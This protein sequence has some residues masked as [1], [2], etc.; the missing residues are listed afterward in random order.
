[1]GFQAGG[2]KG[3]ADPPMPLAGFHRT[4]TSLLPLATARFDM[5]FQTSNNRKNSNKKEKPRMGRL[6]DLFFS[7]G[8][9]ARACCIDVFAP[10]RFEEPISRNP[11]QHYHTLRTWHARINMS[12][13]QCFRP[14]TIND[15]F[16]LPIL[17][18]PLLPLSRPNKQTRLINS[19]SSVF[20]PVATLF[21]PQPKQITDIRD[22]LHTAR[23]KDA[24]SVKIAKRK[25]CTKFKIR[26]SRYLYTLT[27]ED[28]DKAEKLSQ[29]LPPGLTRKEV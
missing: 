14:Q 23:R 2:Q 13:V 29:S 24:K 11:F 22:F 12:K 26:C 28:S 8:F 15:L 3:V 25:T 4:R 7:P 17:L 18:L 19:F 5:L 10:T 21:S 20:L 1:M 9:L 27:V 16:F 6:E